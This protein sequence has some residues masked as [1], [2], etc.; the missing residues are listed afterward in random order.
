MSGSELAQELPAVCYCVYVVRCEAHGVS[1][2][3]LKV[4]WFAAEP[5]GFSGS[6]D[7]SFESCGVFEV[8]AV[9]VAGLGWHVQ[10]LVAKQVFMGGF[11]SVVWVQ[12]S[13]RPVGGWGL[14][15]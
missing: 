10:C 15:C 3:Q 11:L 5:A 1:R 13:P 7:V 2:R 12:K 6:F 8:G 14:L 4:Y 9:V